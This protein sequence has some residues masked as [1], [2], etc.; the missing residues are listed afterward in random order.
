[1]ADYDLAGVETWLNNNSPAVEVL[2]EFR[3]GPNGSNVSTP[4]PQIDRLEATL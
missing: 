2:P 3:N 1:M 4:S